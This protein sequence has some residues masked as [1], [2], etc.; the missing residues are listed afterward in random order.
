MNEIS[1]LGC[2]WLGLPLAEQLVL[3]GW[4]VKGATTRLEKFP[5][6]EE[7]GVLPYQIQADE[8]IPTSDFFDSPIWVIN[9]PPRS[10]T[11]GPEHALK[12]IDHVLAHRKASTWIIFVSST[13]VYPDVN[14]WVTEQEADPTHPLVLVENKVLALVPNSLLLRCSGLMGIDRLPGKY[15][16]G[17]VLDHGGKAP[18]NY[19]HQG[20]VV[21][22]IMTALKQ[23]GKGGIYNIVSPIHPTR[24]EVMEISCQRHEWAMPLFLENAPVEPHKIVSGEAFCRVY[25]FSY[26]WPDPS[27]YV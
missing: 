20:D 2:G 12:Q 22:A 3:D 19:V 10:K 5:L 15:V 23:P 8:P 21:R 11:R 7:K 24:R 27:A 16:Q 1:I 4:M 6:L 26:Q 17:R 14:D 25:D 9:I 13:S 18:V